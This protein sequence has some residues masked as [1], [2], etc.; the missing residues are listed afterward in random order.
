MSHRQ[1]NR[2]GHAIAAKREITIALS[3][4]S[5][6]ATQRCMTEAEESELIHA[7]QTDRSA[8]FGIVRLKNLD[9][10]RCCPSIE[11]RTLIQLSSSLCR[12]SITHS[13]LRSG[14]DPSIST[15]STIPNGPLV[16]HLWSL[17]PAYA[18][19]LINVP[20]SMALQPSKHSPRCQIC[21]QPPPPP[22]QPQPQ[23]HV[24][25]RSTT[26][27]N[28]LQLPCQ[29]VL[30]CECYYELCVMMADGVTEIGCPVVGCS[31]GI[32]GNSAAESPCADD[33]AI[34]A[35]VQSLEHLLVRAEGDAAA[36]ASL[37]TVAAESLSRWSLLEDSPSHPQPDPSA[38]KL[39]RSSQPRRF[40]AASARDL[41]KVNLGR[42][43]E[44]RTDQLFQTCS[45]GNITRL[46][47]L[48]AAGVDVEAR[49]EYFQPPLFIAVWKGHTRVA[50]LLR[51][52]GAADAFDRMGVHSGTLA[53]LISHASIEGNV[54]RCIE[55]AA[56]LS[57]ARPV[58]D[59]AFE[60][61]IPLDSVLQG[62][63]SYILDNFL[64]D[65]FISYLSSLPDNQLPIRPAEKAS[66][67]D[68]YYWSDVQGVLVSTLA[69]ALKL[70]RREERFGNGEERFALRG[71][72]PNMR[73]LAYRAV[74]GVLPPHI[75]LSRSETVYITSEQGVEDCCASSPIINRDGPKKTKTT[76]TST[77]TFILYLTDCSSG[78]ETALLRKLP[79]CTRPVDGVASAEDHENAIVA[80]Q[81][82]RGRLFC[83]PH[84]C[85]HEGRLVQC[86]PK[87]LIRGEMF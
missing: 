37:R 65:E 36:R 31:S 45:T 17:P 11:F 23:P 85:P 52:V 39:P 29:H 64:S 33:E 84:A 10:N 79:A 54:F 63:G 32:E 73:F 43:K 19:F 67:S 5:A 18:V 76:Y 86:V 40:R 68:R 50:R 34:E 57:R 4:S 42:T 13:L 72:L 1:R 46:M 27:S 83:F 14:A 69:M 41:H 30:C 16:L 3:D 20:H 59:W 6:A 71:I 51:M 25:D 66:C 48:L 82:R 61:L 24:L 26:L 44:Q 47:F 38:P 12:D 22:P 56:T 35:Q 28:L 58:S 81:P 80:V 62:A 75:D 55:G 60:T 78:G 8:K 21:Q 87:L 49:N 77:H 7:I 15:H 9:L 2:I 53:A 74:G 70:I